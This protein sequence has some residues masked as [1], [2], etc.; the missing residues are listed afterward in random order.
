MLST[1]HFLYIIVAAVTFLSACT[2]NDISNTQ[3]DEQVG[4]SAVP[5]T[6]AGSFTSANGYSVTGMA[7][8]YRKDNRLIL[9]LENFNSSSGPDLRVYLAKETQPVNFV[10]LGKLKSVSGNQL[11]DI[12]ASADITVFN[13]VLIH[14][15][16]FNRVFGYTTVK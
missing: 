13:N 5:V 2:K 16:Q 11:Y 15:Q 1:K 3:L 14:C 7:R 12:P 6:A 9:A 4:N 10:S 8:I